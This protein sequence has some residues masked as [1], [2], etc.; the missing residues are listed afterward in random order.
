MLCMTDLTYK[1][2]RVV[3]KKIGF[4]GHIKGVSHNFNAIPFSNL[5][6]S[7]K[8]YFKF[9]SYFCCYI[10]KGGLSCE[11]AHYGLSLISVFQEFFASVSKFSVW[12]GMGGDWALGYHSMRFRHSPDIS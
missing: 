12:W 6:I 9:L 8:I 2:I 11:A 3:S 10:Q 7:I 5:R 4:L 1:L